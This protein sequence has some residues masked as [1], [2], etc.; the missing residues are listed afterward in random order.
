MLRL[1]GGSPAFIRRPFLYTGLYFGAGGGL[2]AGV[3]LWALTL[4]LAG[5]VNALFLLYDSPGQLYGPGWRYPLVLIVLGAVL[6]WLA[7]WI[8]SARYFRRLEVH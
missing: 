6:G 3:M 8:A 4:W 7:S 2:L 1:I 5:P